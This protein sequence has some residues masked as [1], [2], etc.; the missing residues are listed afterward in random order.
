MYDKKISTKQPG[1]VLNALDDSESTSSPFPG[2][3]DSIYTWIERF[4]KFNT[5]EM[6]NRSTDISGGE[7]K[8]KPRY[9]I[10]N[11]LYGSLPEVWGE[12]IMDIQS[13]IKKYAEDGNSFG[14]GGL[15]G[16]TDAE[17]AFKKAYEI[18][19]EAVKD[20]RFKDSF[21]PMLF[22]LTDGLSATDAS[23]IA[24]KIKEL[25]TSDGNV[26]IVNAFIGTETSL[27][28]TDQEDFPGYT[29]EE[30]AGPSPDNI[31]LFNMSSEMPEAIYN[32]LVND[33]IFP[34][35][36]E[37]SR[38]FFDVRTKEMLKH[39][40]QVVGSIGSRADRTER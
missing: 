37:N 22:H 31:R 1:L 21:P 5:K 7:G 2:T 11:V 17:A 27:E 40:L 24:E 23:P 28:Y 29:T 33:C 6:M 4:T 39:T 8:I 20:P 18:L 13:V 14:L 26:I 36:R 35:L 12:P 10:S 15:K 16:G 3:T 30:E 9:F 32:N 25:S 19:K 38:L 34:Q